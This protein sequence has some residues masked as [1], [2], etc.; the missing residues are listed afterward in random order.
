MIE[1]LNRM[2]TGAPAGLTLA[3]TLAAL[4][5]GPVA[6]GD[7]LP[8]RASDPAYGVAL[9]EY[10]QGNAFEALTRL[11]VASA[12]G[13]IDGHGDHPALVEG[14]L[15]LSYGMTHEAGALFREL[16]DENAAVAPGTRNQ[17]WFYL[18]K[19]FYLEQDS[20]AARDALER[21]DDELLQPCPERPGPVAKPLTN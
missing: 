21:L 16:L 19:V 2:T 17:A 14:G 12:E 11:N 18:G 8:Q 6:V 7:E 5:H 10:Y 20:T 4:L 15:M 3:G 13:G 1:W 9:Y